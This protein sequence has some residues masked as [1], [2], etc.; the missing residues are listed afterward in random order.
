MRRPGWAG[1]SDGLAASAAVGGWAD[2]PVGQPGLGRIRRGRGLEA[3]KVRARFGFI[4]SCCMATPHTSCL[5][6]C[7]CYMKEYKGSKVVGKTLLIL[8]TF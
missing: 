8:F 2:D 3:T 1:G 6:I 4:C 5:C 7:I